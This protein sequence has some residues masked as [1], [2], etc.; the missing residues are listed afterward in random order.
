M[1]AAVGTSDVAMAD[2][3]V[4]RLGAAGVEPTVPAGAAT[5]RCEACP[6]I[7]HRVGPVR[8]TLDTM[9]GPVPSWRRSGRARS[10]RSSAALG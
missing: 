1:N 3:I 6:C 9:P 5:R 4:V 10:K 2:L 7:A 8:V